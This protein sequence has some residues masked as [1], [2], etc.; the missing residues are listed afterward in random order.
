MLKL[1]L[2]V[3]F[4]CSCSCMS[5]SAES[6]KR[7]TL[8]SPDG[9]RKVFFEHAS[10]SDLDGS[11]SGYIYQSD[12]KGPGTIV[13]LG[14][15]HY[16]EP[17]DFTQFVNHGYESFVQPIK[18]QPLKYEPIRYEPVKYEPVK[19]GHF[20]GAPFLG[21]EYFGGK[22]NVFG[23]NKGY[24]LTGG[25]G[26]FGGEEKGKYLL[27]KGHEGNEEFHHAGGESGGKG[28]KDQDEFNKELIKKLHSQEEE[29]YGKQFGGN[30]KKEY[31]EGQK[32]EDVKQEKKGEEGE[33][34]SSKKSHK[35][36]H[37]TTGF[38][39]VYHKDEYKK[40][41]SFFDEADDDGHH[42]EFGGNHEAH[43][44]EGGAYKK[45]GHHNSGHHEDEYLKKGDFHKGDFESAAKGFRESE[46][47]KKY[48][49]N[50]EEFGNKGGKHF[51]KEYGFGG[52]AGGYGEEY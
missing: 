41:H 22:G 20:E 7:M 42:A 14:E 24:V 46:G 16:V 15:S 23:G 33:N 2:L 4:V 1:I 17:Q 30:K 50:D 5:L 8:T 44:A 10:K 26:L 48:Y 11:A 36:G 43:G 29:G 31:E 12:G 25:E 32:F 6:S 19:F 18:Y 45:A 47:G 37:K 3:G 9:A 21:G 34:F 38:H 39:N 13:H 35:K 40:Q 28:Y 52:H 49:S 27:K 51:K